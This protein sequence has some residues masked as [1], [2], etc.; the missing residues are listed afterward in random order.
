[1]A[2][3]ETAATYIGINNE[4]EFYSHHYLSEV[5]RGDIKAT[6]EAWA[7][8]EAQGEKSPVARLR[9]LYREYFAI[10]ERLRRERGVK[11]RIEL[12]REIFRL[13]AQALDYAWRPQNLILEDDAEIPVLAALDHGGAPE[14]LLIGAYDPEL[15]GAD[16]LSLPPERAQFHG[17]RP[18]DP[19]LLKESW[20][21]II[22]RRIHAQTHPP[23]WIL[24]LSD[25][26]LLLID[27][28]KWN[29]NRLL[30]F[31]WD[32]ILGRRDDATLKA[33]AALLHRDSL[34]P[35]EGRG[36][37]SLL[38]HLDENAH[39]HAFAVSEDLKYALRQSIERLGNEAAR[40]LLDHTRTGYTG[41]QA[42]DPGQLSRECLRYMYRLLFLFYIEAR[43]DLGYAPLQSEAYR[44]GYSLESLRDLE[45]VRLES[46]E[47]RNGYY[48]HHSIQRLFVLIYKGY[49]GVRDHQAFLGLESIH[50]SF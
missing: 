44:R 34:L 22:T 33:A 15:D 9:S 17:E 7:A 28:H 30:R 50:H 12:Q 38:D 26:Q 31:E 5:F 32:E 27:R 14:L 46:E 29:R 4:N 25:R 49:R 1:M 11:A 13:L 45:L 36:G 16:P 42:L 24:L 23:R 48:L 39:K 19:S 41:K 40:Y 35:P 37:Q 47:S 43:P 10:G 3:A 6:L 21:E 20:N 2:L 18:P 8:L